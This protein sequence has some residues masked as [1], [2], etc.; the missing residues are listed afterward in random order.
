MKDL[1]G[2]LMSL[3]TLYNGV[4]PGYQEILF[5]EKVKLACP[6]SMST[7]NQF[8]TQTNRKRRARSTI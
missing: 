8:M 4:D 3:Q 5:M 6:G 1:I 2:L 7:C